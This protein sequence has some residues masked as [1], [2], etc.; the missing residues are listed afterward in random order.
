MTAAIE[1]GLD[2]FGDITAGP[3]GQLQSHAQVIRDVIAEGV[4]ADRLRLEGLLAVGM[5]A[6]SAALGL[7][8]VADQPLDVHL[9]GMMLG[10]SQ[11]LYFGAAQPLW[12]RYFGRAHLGK[13][14][15]VLMTI[16]VALSSMGP[17]GMFRIAT[18]NPGW[19]GD[20]WLLAGLGPTVSQVV[21]SLL[22]L[23]AMAGFIV[24]AGVAVGWL[25]ASWWV[26]VGV[27]ASLASL[28][29]I[30]LFPAAFPLFSTIAATAVDVAVLVGIVRLGWDPGKLVG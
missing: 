7:L 13:I 14:R 8:Y 1:F 27:V 16:I 24:L 18:I 20:S 11:G 9:A 12:A 19:Q 17:L 6:L 30:V 4:L 10:I 2:T 25:P 15:G 29:G 22:W 3:D 23:V 26:P 5:L 28:A 21:G